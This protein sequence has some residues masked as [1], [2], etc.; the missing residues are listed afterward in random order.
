MSDV[1][2]VITGFSGEY[3]EQ[4][5]WIVAV[6]ESRSIAEADACALQMHADAVFARYRSDETELHECE[7]D[8]RKFDPGMDF[9][10]DAP[11]YSVVEAP[12]FRELPAGKGGSDV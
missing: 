5:M 7:A 12:W 6:F 1:A 9:Y 8:L 10:G 4:R 2:F 11:A 3:S